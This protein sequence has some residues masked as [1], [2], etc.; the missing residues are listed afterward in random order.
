MK[1]LVGF[2]FHFSDLIFRAVEVNLMF[3]YQCVCVCVLFFLLRLQ[4][5]MHER[6]HFFCNNFE[7]YNVF[8]IVDMFD[9]VGSLQII[10]KLSN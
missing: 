4:V 1:E 9:V 7:K 2:R 5:F 6:F 8:F 3:V 10:I